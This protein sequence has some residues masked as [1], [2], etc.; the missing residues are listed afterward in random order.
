MYSVYFSSKWVPYLKSEKGTT[1]EITQPFYSKNSCQ[2]L[3]AQES[4][5]TPTA[6]YLSGFKIG[7]AGK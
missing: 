5:L 6:K 2:T 1:L 7:T 3:F 4:D